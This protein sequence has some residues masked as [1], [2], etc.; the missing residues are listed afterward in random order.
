MRTFDHLCAAYVDASAD[1]RLHGITRGL[2][3][4]LETAKDDELPEELHDLVGQLTLR[5]DCD[6]PDRE[7]RRAKTRDWSVRKTDR[8]R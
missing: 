5:D 3:L 8:G 2:S 1:T 4:L 6:G 7:N